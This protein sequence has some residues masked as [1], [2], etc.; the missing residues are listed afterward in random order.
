MIFGKAGNFPPF[1]IAFHPQTLLIAAVSLA[2]DATQ[3]EQKIQQS[4]NFLLKERISNFQ[5][6]NKIE[7]DILSYKR[8]TTE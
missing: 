7:Q 1:S 6:K 5:N 2:S 3:Y 4:V 8:S